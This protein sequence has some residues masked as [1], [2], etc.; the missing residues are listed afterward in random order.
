[1]RRALFVAL[2]ALVMLGSTSAG[3]GAAA[4]STTTEGPFPPPGAV[5]AP[6][7]AST[8][9]FLGALARLDRAADSGSRVRVTLEGA[10]PLAASISAATQQHLG[11]PAPQAVSAAP[12]LAALPAKAPATLV[13]TG[14]D[15]AAKTLILALAGPPQVLASKSNSTTTSSLISIALE[16]DI[17]DEP[18]DVT[19]ARGAAAASL[20][21]PGRLTRSTVPGMMRFDDKSGAALY[22]DVRH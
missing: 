10:P 17:V 12:A 21:A 1:M 15:G 20:H 4:A 11:R 7:A 2:A 9:I 22:I 19:L 3:A 18:K 13:A 16:G 14:A 8:L 5:N 6:A